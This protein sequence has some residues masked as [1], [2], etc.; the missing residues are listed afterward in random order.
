MISEHYLKCSKELLILVQ[1][2][3]NFSAKVKEFKRENI[4]LLNIPKILETEHPIQKNIEKESTISF[5]EC[6]SI[7]IIIDKQTNYPL[8][9]NG[10]LVMDSQT[11]QD[12]IHPNNNNP[13]TFRENNIF[14][15]LV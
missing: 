13:I 8:E 3:N 15:A 14:I 10:F 1:A 7:K 6:K 9:D 4:K 11:G 2:F 12:I 5:N